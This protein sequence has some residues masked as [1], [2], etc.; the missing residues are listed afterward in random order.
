MQ[1][2]S[3]VVGLLF[4]VPV[5]GAA[6]EPASWPPNIIFIMADDKS[7]QCFAESEE[8]RELGHFPEFFSE[9]GKASQSV[10]YEQL[11]AI[12]MN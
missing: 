1:R 10:D 7:Y 12:R 2:N 5:L 11:I 3:T 6:A 8:V 4:L 9:P